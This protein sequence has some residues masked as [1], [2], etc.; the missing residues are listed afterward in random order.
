MTFV[1][2]SAMA[3]RQ[4]ETLS[5]PASTNSLVPDPIDAPKLGDV[6]SSGQRVQVFAVHDAELRALIQSQMPETPVRQPSAMRQLFAQTLERL[7]SLITP[8]DFDSGLAL[9]DGPRITGFGS[10]LSKVRG[11]R[12]LGTTVEDLRPQ[13]EDANIPLL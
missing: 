6:A 5:L 11:A 9:A 3:V 12:L 7:R 13:P 10:A 8:D 1:V 4:S 2:P